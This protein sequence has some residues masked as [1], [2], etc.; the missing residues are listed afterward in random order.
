MLYGCYAAYATDAINLWWMAGGLTSVLVTRGMM[1][2][3]TLSGHLA[4]LFDLITRHEQ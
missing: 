1:A 2:L 4:A 3:R